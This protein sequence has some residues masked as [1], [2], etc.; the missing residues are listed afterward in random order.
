MNAFPVGRCDADDQRSFV[1]GHFIFRVS[2]VRILSKVSV[3]GPSA[4]T[5]EIETP[6]CRGTQTFS[7]R[8]A[9]AA[10]ANS[11]F[12]ISTDGRSSTLL[13]P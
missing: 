13:N 2:N 12:E 6:R 7:L 8:Q 9:K 1:A 4:G 11:S 5:V 3:G 10:K